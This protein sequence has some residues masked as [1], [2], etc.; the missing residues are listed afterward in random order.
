[1]GH[2]PLKKKCILLIKNEKTYK[3][4]S[5]ILNKTEK[6]IRSFLFRNGETQSKYKKEY[7]NICINCNDT[8]KA[9]PSDNRKFCTHKCSATY[10]NKIRNRKIKCLVCELVLPRK[11]RYFCSKKCESIHISIKRIERIES[12]YC[13]SEKLVK[14]YLIEKYG[15]KCME[16]GW[17]EV[18]PLLKKV[19]VQ[20]EHIDG[21]SENNNLSNLKIL[22]PNCH[23]LTLTFGAL[24]KG[25]GRKNRYK[26]N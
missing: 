22:C 15:E 10:N 3:E 20:L 19:P 7:I 23:S 21:N 6:S 24:N 11:G 17:C 1:M 2:F 13:T 8:F 4:I 25:R 26:T 16:C 5:I 12:G 9:N 14:N 18:H